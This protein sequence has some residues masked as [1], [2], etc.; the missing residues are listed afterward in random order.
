MTTPELIRAAILGLLVGIA[1]FVFGVLIARQARAE[2][3]DSRWVYRTVRQQYVAYDHWTGHYVHRYR[4]VQQRVRNHTYHIP[5]TRVYSYVRRDDDDDRNARVQCLHK[6][7]TIDVLS[8]EH[9][10]EEAAREAAKKLWMA[11]TQ[12]ELGGQF[13]NLEEASDVRW[14]CG[15]SNAHDTVSGRLAEAAG[16]LTGRGGQNVRWA[17]AARPCKGPRESD[18]GRR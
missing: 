8:T 5:E 14:R 16:T 3:D 13:M 17:L 12:W 6:S 18:R 11:K 10:T 4:Y 9:Q 1:L 7:Q 2:G 15:P